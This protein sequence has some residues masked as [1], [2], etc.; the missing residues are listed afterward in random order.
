MASVEYYKDFPL[1]NKSMLEEM[2]KA[3]K[4]STDHKKHKKPHKWTVEEMQEEAKRLRN[5]AR[6]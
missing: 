4:R 2:S 3:G 6:R 5:E 1:K